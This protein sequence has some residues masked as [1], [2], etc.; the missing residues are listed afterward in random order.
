MTVFRSFQIHIDPP[1]SSEFHL[2]MFCQELALAAVVI[3]VSFI[4]CVLIVGHILNSVGWR[5]HPV[6]S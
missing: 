4:L 1:S 2:Y 6:P 3:A 5:C